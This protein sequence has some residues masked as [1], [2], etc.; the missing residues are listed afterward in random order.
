MTQYFRKHAEIF[1]IGK[2]ECKQDL[3]AMRWT[4][5]EPQDFEFIQKVYEELYPR[6]ADF[7][8]ED[9]LRLLERRPELL[10]MNQG[11]QR[12]EGLLKSLREDEELEKRK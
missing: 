2:M 3:N 7:S 4:V 9:I 11:I 8:M 5:D 6:N 1:K 12:N 10:F